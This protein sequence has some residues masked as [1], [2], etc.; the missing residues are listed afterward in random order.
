MRIGIIGAG[1]SGLTSALELSKLGHE[2]FVFEKQILETSSQKRHLSFNYTINFRGMTFLKKIGVWEQVYL[3]S[4]PLIGRIIHKKK[5]LKIIQNYTKQNSEVL[6]SIPRQVL[7]EI[8]LNKTKNIDLINLHQEFKIEKIKINKRNVLI[9]KQEE[10]YNDDF[11]FD[12]IIGAD[13]AES[14]LRKEFNYTFESRIEEFDWNYIDV[15]LSRTECQNLQ[16][17]T[18][19]IH[20]WPQ[21]GCLGVGIPNK[22]HSLSLLHIFK[23]NLTSANY[24]QL[25]KEQIKNYLG[26]T[27]KMESYEFKRFGRMLSVEAKKWYI[28]DK[29]VLIGD[30]AHAFLPFLGQGMNAAIQDVEILVNLLQNYPREEAF[31]LFNYHRKPETDFL[32]KKSRKHFSY[33]KKINK[34]SI[35]NSKQYFDLY[36]SSLFGN[37]WINEYAALSNSS[38]NISLLKKRLYL[39]KFIQYTPLYIMGLIIYFLGSSAHKLWLKVKKHRLQN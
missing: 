33:L 2:I 24:T 29:I 11:L 26:S 30:A 13:G 31:S 8:L 4:Q 22:D 18:S 36:L 25:L 17:S 35:S 3:C 12:F 28:K 15:Q 1:I 16:L 6:Y 20:V 21:K 7:L 39:Q 37:L 5:E 27:E 14:K 9:K 34:L 32:K 38:L 10:L 23:T 19:H